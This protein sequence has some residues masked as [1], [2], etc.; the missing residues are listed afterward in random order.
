ML[1]AHSSDMDTESLHKQLASVPL[2]A[3][4]DELPS[5]DLII[6]ETIRLASSAMFTLLRR[7]VKTDI[8]AEGVRISRG[9]FIAYS[10][11]DVHMNK[12]V[13]TN[14]ETFDPG[15]YEDGRKEDKRVSFGFVGW[16]AGNLVSLS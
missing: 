1:S 10:A 13:Y 3:W 16:G 14:P 12:N 4:E 2:H 9:D 5:L 6:R 15:R 11:A 7:N 8:D